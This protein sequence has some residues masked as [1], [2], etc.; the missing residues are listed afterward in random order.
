MTKR[1]IDGVLLVDKPAGIT[2]AEVVRI[3]KRRLNAKKVGHG[4]TLDPLG[5]GLLVILLGRAT[6]LSSCFLEGEKAYSGIIRLG[7]STDTE[8]MSGLTLETDPAVEEKFPQSLWAELEAKV[9][10][11]FSGKIRQVPPAYSAIKIDGRRSYD[12]ARQG[13]AVA[14]EAREV[15]ISELRLKFRSA[16]ELEYFVRC[17]KGTYVRSLAR[18]IALFL[19]SVGCIASLR[20]EACGSFQLSSASVLDDIKPDTLQRH[21]LPQS[22]VADGSLV[23][24]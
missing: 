21:L 1:E 7:I 14:H 17:S 2:S 18:D 11:A 5:T 24:H 23:V 8:D 20:R 13:Q 10:Q 4:G 9:T 3:L 22:S 15:F 12:L 19:D 16:S 6:K